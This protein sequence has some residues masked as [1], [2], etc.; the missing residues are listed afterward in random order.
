MG[1]QILCARVEDDLANQTRAQAA[2]RGSTVS[3]AI[4]S[5]LRALLKRGSSV[6]EKKVVK[7]LVHVAE[8]GSKN[9]VAEAAGIA[10]STADTPKEAAFV[11]KTALDLAEVIDHAQKSVKK[12]KAAKKKAAKKKVSPKK[13]ASKK[14]VPKKKAAPKKPAKKKAAP[15]KTA[16]KKKSA[17]KKS[18]GKKASQKKSVRAKGSKK[19]H[20]KA[21][22]AAH[23]GKKKAPRK[24]ASKKSPPAAS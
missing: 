2:Q 4:R 13:T 17:A 7:A 19:S 18:G 14:A 12:P 24:K 15:K 5:G 6:W 22:P 21:A 10:L 8:T 16:A 1:K 3:A 11:R 20:A 23:Q 9:D